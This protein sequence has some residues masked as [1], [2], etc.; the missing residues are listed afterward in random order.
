[1]MKKY[2]ELIRIKHWFKNILIFLPLFFSGNLLNINKITYSILAFIAFSTLASIVYIINDIADL[3]KDKK[4]PIKKHR[5]LA[6]NQISLKS[7]YILMTLLTII[8]CSLLFY[9]YKN[10]DNLLIIIIPVCYLIINILYSYILKKIPIVDVSIIVLGFVLRALFGGIAIDIEVSKYLYLLI[11]FGGL[12]LALGKRKGEINKNDQDTREVLSKYNKEFLDKNMYVSLT[13]SLVCY[14]LW[15]V[16]EN[17]INKIGHD[18]T[19]WTIPLLM[20]IFEIYNLNIDDNSYADPVEVILGSKVLLSVILLYI[21][22]MG[23]L[24]YVI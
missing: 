9:L 7:A 22:V 12:Y 14:I 2:L 17:V 8:L 20:I 4:H 24:I 3:E 16:D 23:T 10:V 19:F 15:C 18:Y 6:S 1:M 13:I 5:P 11:I 21:L